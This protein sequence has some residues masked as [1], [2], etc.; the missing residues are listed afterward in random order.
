MDKPVIKIQLT[1][2]DKIAEVSGYILLAALWCL[3]VYFYNNSPD[4]V[5]IHFNL[6]GEADGYGTRKTMFIT[7]VLCTFLFF[8]LTEVAKHPEMFNYPVTITPQNAKKQYTIATCLLRSLKIIVILIFGLIDV[9]TYLT[10]IQSNTSINGWLMPV[11]FII[12]FIPV[13]YYFIKSLNAE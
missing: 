1:T 7:P 11:I 4:V 6:A 12:L 13:V 3:V 10:A 9:H 2:Q 5:P 8:M